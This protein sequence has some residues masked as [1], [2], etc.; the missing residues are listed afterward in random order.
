MFNMKSDG[1]WTDMRSRN[2]SIKAEMWKKKR[3]GNEQPA[4]HVS[5]ESTYEQP[6]S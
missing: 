5:S 6:S 1:K 2:L 3:L 4:V